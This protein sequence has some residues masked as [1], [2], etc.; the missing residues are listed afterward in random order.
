MSKR[1][2]TFNFGQQND[3][4]SEIKYSKKP[5]S[6]ELRKRV[7]Y[8]TNNSKLGLCYCCKH[9]II[10]DSFHVG[11]IVAE[12]MGGPTKYE[13]LMAICSRCNHSMHTMHMFDYIKKLH[14]MYEHFY[15]KQSNLLLDYKIHPDNKITKTTNDYLAVKFNMTSE[16]VR[17]LPKYETNYNINEEIMHEDFVNDEIIDYEEHPNDDEPDKYT[18]LVNIIRQSAKKYRM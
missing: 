11:H 5:I 4:L 2:T 7:W 6:D 9:P 16:L 18:D 10:I 3:E 17:T 15:L 8:K 1:T 12:S 14:W 13:N